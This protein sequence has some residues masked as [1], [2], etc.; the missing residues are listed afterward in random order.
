M[1]FFKGAFPYTDVRKAGIVT[2]LTIHAAFLALLL[3]IPSAKPITFS[4]TIQISLGH[5]DSIS[6]TGL[7][8]EVEPATSKP[9]FQGKSEPG[10]S[11]SYARGKTTTDL[12]RPTKLPFESAPVK[13]SPQNRSVSSLAVSSAISSESSAPIVQE[14]RTSPSFSNSGAEKAGKVA[15]DQNMT[16]GEGGKIGNRSI[17]ET[18]FGATGAPAFIDRVIPVYP[19][20]ARRL[21][22]EG[23]VVL[24]LLIDRHG[25]LRSIEV[26][27]SA[28]FGFLEATIT[29]A[30]QSTYA[31]AI[32]NGKAVAS[33][34]ILPV[35]FRLD[36]R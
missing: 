30:K 22:R 20:L 17:V 36:E 1:T 7:H 12:P 34:A 2:S 16:E 18:S 13:E 27:E 11:I 8:E 33:A 5:W 25:K 6:A 3:L 23:R 9:Y 29:A 26:L 10:R 21:G 28:G 4:K 35:R 32:R 19:S 14:K 31:P 24:K 15:Q